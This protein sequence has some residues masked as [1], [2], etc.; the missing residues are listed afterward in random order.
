METVKP[1]TVWITGL[2][3]S[4]KTSVGKELKKIFIIEG[5]S[6]V[7]LDGDEVRKGLCVDLGFS[8]EDRMEN[9]RRVSNVASIL[10]TQGYIAICCLVSPT[11]EMRG[12]ARKIIGSENF[13]EVHTNASVEVCRKRDF[14]GYYQRALKG[15]ISEFTGVT[16][17]YE[18]PVNPN[19]SVNT[20]VVGVNEAATIIFQKC[21]EWLQD[22]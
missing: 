11:K 13:F 18:A 15:E 9:I 6:V 2:P 17:L 4:G 14:K 20:D 22:R 21:K 16:S 1:F 10:N 3:A 7:L 8:L 12:N 19:V 5:F